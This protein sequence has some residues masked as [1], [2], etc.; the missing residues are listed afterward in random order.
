M[1][2]THVDDEYAYAGVKDPKVCIST[3]RDPSSRLRQF[4]KEMRFIFPNSQRINRGNHKIA[5]LIDACRANN[6]TDLIMF[7][8][9][10]GEPVGMV[11]CHMP[12]GPTAYF[13]ISNA[14]MRHDIEGT[15]PMSEAFPHLIFE[16]FQSDLGKRL[17]AILKYLFPVPKL[18]SKRVITF[19][20]DND[21]ISFRHHTFSRESGAPTKDD[22]NLKEIGPR[23]ELR[24]YK[25]QLGTM[26]QTEAEVEWALRPYMNTA[27][28]RRYM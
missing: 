9:H 12:Y 19:A 27:K 21:F 8:E 16:N 5:E 17:G 6:F 25:I 11:V 3:S 7:Q 1:Q 13:G 2:K 18:D 26:D 14:V 22:V 20:N 10:R 15:A 23:F 28:K 24:P 4:V